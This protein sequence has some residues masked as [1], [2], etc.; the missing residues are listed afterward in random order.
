MR[1]SVAVSTEKTRVIIDTGPD[2]RQQCLSHQIDR[3]SAVLITHLH[4]D[5][6]FGLDDVRKFNM[7]Q[8]G[9]MPVYVP[10]SMCYHFRE[11]F[12]YAL[13]NDNPLLTRPK[14]DLIPLEWGRFDVGDLS[15]EAFPVQHGDDTIAAFQFYGNQR[16]FAYLT[17]CKSMSSEVAAQV[18]GADVI[19][20][21]ALW[22]DERSHPNH[23]NLAE[24]LKMADELQGRQTFLTHI[25]HRMGRHDEV[26]AR[27][28]SHVKLA[29][30]GQVT[31]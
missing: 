26:N 24:A 19:V 4:A 29:F 31:C 28:P 20:L 8:A 1:C 23:L 22:D 25:T 17:D 27:L 2:F 6:I 11:I 30:D 21:G 15:I 7:L 10:A 13:E 16:R 5:H 18:C 14:F 3:L 12:A 9:S